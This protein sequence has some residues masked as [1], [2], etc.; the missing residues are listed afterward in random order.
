MRLHV[1]HEAVSHSAPRWIQLHGC[2]CKHEHAEPA[3]AED[4]L[5]PFER[6]EPDDEEEPHACDE[7][8]Q[9]VGKPREKLE[10]DREAAD[11][12]GQRQQVDNL[13]RDQRCKPGLETDAFSNGVE[14]R[15]PGD[16]SDSAAHL[17]V[18]DDPHHSDDDHP[19]QLVAERRARGDV[20]HEV[21]DV[22][23]AAD[24]SEDP[25]RDLED[26]HFASSSA[27]SA[28][29]LNG[30]FSDTATPRSVG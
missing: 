11:L 2:N 27:A 29:S 9:A 12:C 28:S 23:E 3:V 5:D 24:R 20:E 22:D 15:F 16:R 21:T 18:H 25:E 30:F 26:L 4:P 17:R 1:R 10:A 6:N 13:R 7:D 14:D 19:Q 8:Q